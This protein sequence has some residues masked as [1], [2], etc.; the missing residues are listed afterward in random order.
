MWEWLDN[1]S[2]MTSNNETLG[3]Q[4]RVHLGI[5]VK[6]YA[7]EN[8]YLQESRGKSP[9]TP[10][11]AGQLLFSKSK[12]RAKD[13]ITSIQRSLSSETLYLW[14]K[15]A[16]ATAEAS[17]A[18][19]FSSLAGSSITDALWTILG[20]RNSRNIYRQKSYGNCLI[21]VRF[22]SYSASCT[23]EECTQCDKS[24]PYRFIM[25]SMYAMDADKFW[26]HCWTVS[27]YYDLTSWK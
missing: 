18:T 11:K 17:W 26:R 6:N 7:Y 16:M 25:D 27:R 3:C 13:F 24:K 5:L 19:A 2:R 15:Y 4:R 12:E 23:D 22:T 21:L 10:A 14:T 1:C 20:R 9:I 8:T